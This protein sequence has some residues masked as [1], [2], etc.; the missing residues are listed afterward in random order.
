VLNLIEGA[1][2]GRFHPNFDRIGGLKDDL[3]KGWLDE[4]RQVMKKLR[5]FCDEIEDLLFGN[6]IFQS[7]TRGIGVIPADVARQYGLSGAN[8]RASGVDWDL[9]R[10]QSLPL[11][12]DK[13]D[14][15]V[16]THPDGDAWARCWIRLQEV[17]EA[18]KIVDQLI[19][20]L[21]AGP[22][23]TK[24]PRIIKVPEGEAWVST[25]N[26]L[27]EMGYYV[28]SKGDLGP[29]RVKIR[30]ASFNNISITPW[31]LKGVYVPDIITILA[32]LYFILGDI[33]R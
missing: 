4:T 31:V 16:W 20:T 29:F 33:D 7:R 27:G 1:T 9:R 8:L 18:T 19:E 6:E 17:R 25:E 28:V 26:P 14:F 32:S 30:S 15:R 3:P 2:G 23:M 12:Y 5:N 21:P 10:D 24:V 13:V 22:V 11:A